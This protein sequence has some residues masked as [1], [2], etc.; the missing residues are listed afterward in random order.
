M[1]LYSQTIKLLHN[2]KTKISKEVLEMLDK[3][4]I[5]EIVRDRDYSNWFYF[6]IGSTAKNTYSYVYLGDKFAFHCPTVTVMRKIDWL[7]NFIQRKIYGMKYHK[8]LNI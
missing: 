6:V 3:C 2:E 4:Y 7:G 8:E 1:S 5:S